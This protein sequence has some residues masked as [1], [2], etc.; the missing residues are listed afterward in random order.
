MIAPWSTLPSVAIWS[1][2]SA[3]SV[4]AKF[5]MAVDSGSG[6]RPLNRSEKES[7]LGGPPLSSTN[8]LKNSCLYL[9]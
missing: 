7:W 5:V 3:A 1:G 4:F 2:G 9:A 8:S 6:S